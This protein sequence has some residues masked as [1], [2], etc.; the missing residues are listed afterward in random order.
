MIKKDRAGLEQLYADGYIY[1]HSNGSVTNRAQDIGETMSSDI[2]WT[3]GTASDMK[4]RVYG[5]MALVLGL[6]T[7]QGAAKG[8]VPGARRFTDVFVKRNG[9]WQ[10]LGGVSTIVAAANAQA[11]ANTTAISPVKTL[12]PKPMMPS[13]ADE[14]AVFAAEQAYVQAD[15]GGDDA[16]SRALQTKD[17]T[18]VSRAGLLQLPTDPPATKN[19]SIVVAYDHVQSTAGVVVIHGSLLWTD[20]KGFSPGAPRFMR[21]WVKQ[22]TE[23]KLAAE[24][25]TPLAG[26]VRPTGH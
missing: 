22:G 23:W 21:V 15:L 1:T 19:K 26:A 24:Q 6:S 3:S 10:Q 11:S 14:R 2:K 17:Y 12:A 8:Y 5:D 9:R 20:V 25:R 18:F 13:S 4:V 16:K 7:L